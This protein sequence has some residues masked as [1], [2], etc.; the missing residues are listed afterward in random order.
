MNYKALIHSATMG[1]PGRVRPLIL[2]TVFEYFLR[3]APYGILLM[4]V[5]EIFKPLETPGTALDIT[6][7]TLWC[8]ALLVS[9]VLLFF[10]SRKAYF[11]SYKG[12][13]E[14]CADGRLAM[15]EHLRRQPMGFYNTRDPGDI[16]AYIVSDYA[17]VEQLLTHQLPQMAGGLAAPLALLA[18]MA[19]MSWKLALAAAPG[20]APGL[21]LF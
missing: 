5:W 1:R 16:G 12:G 19:V 14:I 20:P 6:C 8:L 17:N 13:Y 2:W 18:V 10:V 7:I 9:L 11:A 3:G 21:D 15:V 4:V